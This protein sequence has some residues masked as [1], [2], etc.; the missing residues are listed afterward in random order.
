MTACKL[1]P[2]HPP[3]KMQRIK[4]SEGELRSAFFHCLIKRLDGGLEQDGPLNEKL[5]ADTEQGS[6]FL[7]SDHSFTTYEIMSSKNILI[8]NKNDQ[9]VTNQ[10]K[11]GY[12]GCKTSLKN[13]VVYRVSKKIS[14]H[15]SACT[16]GYFSIVLAF[17]I[18]IY[19]S[20]K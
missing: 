3:S 6:H 20:G 1:V 13:S 12:R 5:E 19:L 18:L 4:S 10:R 8:E 15:V 2:R 9:T 14:F 11:R 7:Q 17:F 16:T